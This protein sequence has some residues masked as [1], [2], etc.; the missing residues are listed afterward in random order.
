VD[1]QVDG[2]LFGAARAE[3]RDDEKQEQ[4]RARH[5]AK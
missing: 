5:S 1:P 2:R 4:N 3:Q